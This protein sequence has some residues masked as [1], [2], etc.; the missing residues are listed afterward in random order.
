M[1]KDNDKL[2]V[3]PVKR[4]RTLAEILP[5]LESLSEAFPAIDDPSVKP[6]DIF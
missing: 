1:Y 3:E 6:E 2:I 4:V 5:T